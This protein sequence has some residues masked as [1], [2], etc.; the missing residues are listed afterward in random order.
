MLFPKIYNFFA[1]NL[2]FLFY[3]IFNSISQSISLIEKSPFSQSIPVIVFSYDR[4]F[5]LN[6]LLSSLD[7]NL[8]P[9]TIVHVV[10]KCSC[11]AIRQYYEDIHNKYAAEGLHRINFIYEDKSFKVSTIKAL[12][13]CRLQKVSHVL[14]MVDDQIMFRQTCL[15]SILKNLNKHILATFRFG[16]NTSSSFNLSK[17]QSLEDYSPVLTDEIVS[18]K[19]VFAND[20]FSYVFSLDA[21]IFP[22]TI[23]LYFCCTLQYKGPNSLESSMNYC[24]ALFKLFRFRLF[25]LLDQTCVNIP[26]NLVQ[27]EVSNINLGFSA[28]ELISFYLNGKKVIIPRDK[29]HLIDSP[30]T[31]SNFLIIS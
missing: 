21:T 27:E 20:E 29:A 3:L 22:L 5:Q 16:L 31:S 10:C 4:P 1:A 11:K 26:F 28:D 18:W 7:E 25:A 24:A 19:P 6:S 13:A 2:S 12:L 17:H 15:S 14:F 9:P 30:H 8:S 23:A